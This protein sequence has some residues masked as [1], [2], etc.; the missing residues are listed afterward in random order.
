MNSDRDEL[1][2]FFDRFNTVYNNFKILSSV[3]DLSFVGRENKCLKTLEMLDE[4]VDDY[5]ENHI[6]GKDKKSIHINSVLEGG[7][8]SNKLV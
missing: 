7:W 5:K 4:K 8:R 2:K 6:K 3:V 1:N